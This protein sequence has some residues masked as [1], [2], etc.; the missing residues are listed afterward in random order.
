MDLNDIDKLDS[1][2]VAEKLSHKLKEFLIISVAK[3]TQVV[4]LDRG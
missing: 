4:S 2:R 3:Q 1:Q